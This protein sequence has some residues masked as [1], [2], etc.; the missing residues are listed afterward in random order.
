MRAAPER[1]AR[2]EDEVL[3]QATTGGQSR[4]AA[5]DDEQ[6][7]VLDCRDAREMRIGVRVS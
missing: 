3:A 5:G 2:V 6:L 1:I 7:A 4:N